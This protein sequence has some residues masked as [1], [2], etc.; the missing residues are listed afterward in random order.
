VADLEALVRQHLDTHPEATWE[1]A[2]L[3]IING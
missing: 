2:L 1:D 3:S